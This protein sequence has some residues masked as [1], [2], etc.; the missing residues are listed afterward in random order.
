MNKLRSKIFEPVDKILFLMKGKSVSILVTGIGLLN[1]L[2]IVVVILFHILVKSPSS[3]NLTNF[4]NSY[5]YPSNLVFFTT[6]IGVNWY[7]KYKNDL[8]ISS[9]KNSKTFET[10]INNCVEVIRSLEKFRNDIYEMQRHAKIGD[11]VEANK[12]FLNSKANWN[13]FRENLSVSKAFFDI[14]TFQETEINKFRNKINKTFKYF[15][16]G[17]YEKFSKKMESH[18]NELREFQN[19]LIKSLR[20]EMNKGIKL[21]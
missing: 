2:F 20:N 6:L 21:D 7:D 5:G 13:V 12:I 18:N 17:D 3:A 19:S 15:D 14:S 8:S 16:A 9:F 4:L 11:I 1:I 10:Q